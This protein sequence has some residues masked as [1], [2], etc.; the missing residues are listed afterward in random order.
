MKGVEGASEI[1]DAYVAENDANIEKNKE[2]VYE[3]KFI[4]WLTKEGHELVKSECREQALKI[5]YEAMDRFY[6]LSD[7]INGYRTGRE[8][9]EEEIK[10][11]EIVTSKEYV[12]GDKCAPIEDFPENAKEI[13]RCRATFYE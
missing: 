10:I 7:K 12:A 1:I 9:S 5:E 13:T 4:Y 6:R 11:K 3:A 8:D 2:N